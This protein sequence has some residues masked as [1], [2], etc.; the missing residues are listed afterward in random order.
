MSAHTISA[1][2]APNNGM[3]P[4]RTSM[5]VIRKIESLCSCVR[6]GDAGRYA[7]N[8]LKGKK[9]LN[10]TLTKSQDFEGFLEELQAEGDRACAII[11][12]AFLDEHLKQLSAGSSSL[13]KVMP[14]PEL[15]SRRGARP[16]DEH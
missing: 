15:G 11:A 8:A 10:E 13:W 4:T 7:S 2:A 5:D 3:R 6:A 12:A 1:G 9:S 14:S 16:E